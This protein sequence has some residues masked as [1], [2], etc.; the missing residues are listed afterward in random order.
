MA[1]AWWGEAGR[2]GLVW[3]VHATAR[4]N[5]LVRR[6][7]EVF[8]ARF[9]GSSREWV[10][11]LMTGGPFPSGPGLVWSDLGATRLFEWRRG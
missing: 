3:V 8:A 4:N 9:P 1:A 7:P 11:A 10:R 2:V 5:T 6:Y